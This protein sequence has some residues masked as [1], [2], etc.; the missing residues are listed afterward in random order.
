MLVNKVSDM[1]YGRYIIDDVLGRLQC[2]P[3]PL[4]LYT[5]AQLHAYTS[6]FLPDPLTG[7]T[8]TEEA[9]QCLQSG[10]CQPWEPLRAP[11]QEVLATL[12][13]LTPRRSYYPKELKTQ[14]TVSWNPH[15]TTTIQHESFFVRGQRNFE[16]I[17]AIG[18]LQFRPCFIEHEACTNDPESSSSRTSSLAKTHL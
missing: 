8:G 12:A 13:D 18:R 3:E 2:P 15:L 4:L 7:R 10:G 14:Q 9:L 1:R 17:S 5:K 6:F 11:G 16:Q